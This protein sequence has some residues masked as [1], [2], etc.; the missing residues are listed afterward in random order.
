MQNQRGNHVAAGRAFTQNR[1]SLQ[2]EYTNCLGPLKHQGP[3]CS[4]KWFRIWP[5]VMKTWMII[6][7]NAV[8]C[9][10][11]YVKI[12]QIM[13]C[14]C[15]KVSCWRLKK[16][17]ESIASRGRDTISQALSASTIRDGMKHGQLHFILSFI[18]IRNWSQCWKSSSLYAKKVWILNQN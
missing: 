2:A 17:V 6:Y 15:R 5:A 7:F 10:P 9:L 14:E 16:R 12:C 1:S 4:Q 11:Y 18:T 8:R 3:P 13:Q